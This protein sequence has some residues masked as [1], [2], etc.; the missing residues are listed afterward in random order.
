LQKECKRFPPITSA[1][2]RAVVNDVPEAR[3]SRDLA[4]AAAQ[5]DSPLFPLRKDY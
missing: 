3:Q 4:C 2:K 5:V 1:Q